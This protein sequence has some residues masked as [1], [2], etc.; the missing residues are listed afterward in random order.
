MEKKWFEG[1]NIIECSIGEIENIIENHG[2]FFTGVASFMPGLT[3][4]ELIDEGKDHVI[5]KTNEG[6]MKRTNIKKRHE[7]NKV[8]IEFD[9]EYQ[10]HMV[11]A[12]SHYLE[13]FITSE[14]G[15]NHRTVISD[16]KAPGLVGFFYRSFGSANIGKAVLKSFKTYLEMLRD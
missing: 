4:V 13:E 15:V 9:E 5:I 10:A 12:N 6:I 14:D 3:S 11:T 2:K 1:S 16:I 7:P 8:V